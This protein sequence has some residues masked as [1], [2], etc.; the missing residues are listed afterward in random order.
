MRSSSS[1]NLR[2]AGTTEARFFLYLDKSLL[3]FDLDHLV[4]VL[5]FT[6]YDMYPL[7]KCHHEK[8]CVMPYIE[9][10][11]LKTWPPSS[12]MRNAYRL[13]YVE[14]AHESCSRLDSVGAGIANCA[15]FM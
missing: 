7:K 11:R 8:P 5:C 4:P 14:M 3:N 13:P 2:G 1:E 15:V 9:L 12:S 6:E 10:D